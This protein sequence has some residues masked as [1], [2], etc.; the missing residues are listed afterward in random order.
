MVCHQEQ[1]IPN[2]TKVILTALMIADDGK[3]D[4]FDRAFLQSGTIVPVM[5]MTKNLKFVESDL[6]KRVGC[7]SSPDPII[8]LRELPVFI[9]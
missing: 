9:I 8:C 7:D 1:V 5:D 3:L 4:L 6:L 2:L